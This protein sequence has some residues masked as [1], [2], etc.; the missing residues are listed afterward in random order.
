[1][2]NVG[3]FAGRQAAVDLC[4][5]L[6]VH[7]LQ[8][9]PPGSWVEHL[10]NSRTVCLIFVPFLLGEFFEFAGADLIIDF[11]EIDLGV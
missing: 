4:D 7:Q 8:E 3:L 9:D 6:V 1:M 5:D 10:F 11:V 2:V